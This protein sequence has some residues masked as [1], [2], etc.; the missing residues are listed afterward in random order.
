[1]KKIQSYGIEVM[2]GFIVGFDHD[3]D[4]IFERMVDFIKDSAIPLAMVGLLTALPN[5]Q[6]WRRLSGR[7]AL[8]WRECGKQHPFGSELR[9]DNGSHEAG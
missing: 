5:T 6:L 3:P 2:A 8:A 9:H 4:D 1:V 7:R